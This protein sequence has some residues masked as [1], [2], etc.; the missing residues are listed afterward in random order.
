M[1]TLSKKDAETLDLLSL[2]VGDITADHDMKL[3]SLLKLISEK[4]ENPINENNKKIMIFSAFA[5]TA[6]YLYEEISQYVKTKYNLDVAVVT[7]S[8]EEEL[9]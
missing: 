6:M 8:I 4:I 7:G 1:A 9:Q 2:M 5:D 3:Q